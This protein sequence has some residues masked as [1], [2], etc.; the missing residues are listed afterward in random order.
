MKLRAHEGMQLGEGG[1]AT[2]YEAEVKAQE[3]GVV[4]DRQRAYAVKKVRTSQHPGYLHKN[5]ITCSCLSLCKAF[6]A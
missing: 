6:F 1:A 5:M 3:L 4:I 2:V